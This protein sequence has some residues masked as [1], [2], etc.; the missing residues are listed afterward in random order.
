M[1]IAL[2][3]WETFYN[4]KNGKQILWLPWKPG[5]VHNTLGGASVGNISD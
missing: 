1:G 3:I 4:L 5:A 2:M